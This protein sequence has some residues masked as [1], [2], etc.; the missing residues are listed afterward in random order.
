M[1]RKRR[2]AAACWWGASASCPRCGGCRSASSASPHPWLR[3]AA[4]A[5]GGGSGGAVPGSRPATQG[6]AASLVA[7]QTHSGPTPDSQPSAGTCRDLQGPAVEPQQ[8]QKLPSSLACCAQNLNGAEPLGRQQRRRHRRTARASL[9]WRSMQS[10]PLHPLTLLST[11]FCRV[12]GQQSQVKVARMPP[13]AGHAA[14]AEPRG[15]NTLPL[16]RHPP[17]PSSLYV[18]IFQSPSSCSPPGHSGA[19]SP[20]PSPPRTRCAARDAGHCP[21]RR[22]TGRRWASVE[23]RRAPRRS[24]LTAPRP[25][26]RRRRHPPVLLPRTPSVHSGTASATPWAAAPC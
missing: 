16:R 24:R 1:C 5:G 19:G 8:H 11:Q 14:P 25:P 13:A 18:Q 12:H 4:A 23:V 17:A 3:A 21:I 26:P 10:L 20:R 6:Q 7:A 9:L 15:L 2:T 22:C